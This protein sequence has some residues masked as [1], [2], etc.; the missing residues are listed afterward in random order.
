MSA[1]VVYKI[2]IGYQDF[3]TRILRVVKQNF[4]LYIPDAL[5][6]VLLIIPPYNLEK[7]LSIIG[8]LLILGI[9]DIIIM[10]RNIKY[11]N[12]FEVHNGLVYFSI[13]KYSDVYINDH[14]HITNIDMEWIESK[15][16]C[17]LVI[18]RKNS[19]IHTQYAIGYWTKNRLKELYKEFKEIKN[20][21][22]IEDIFRGPILN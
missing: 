19:I 15:N 12:N 10:K 4:L 8:G 6:I 14:D 2:E 5:L 1:D 11:L 7:T 9:R 3:T 18:K 22:N 16:N 20:D 17:R 13:L 21:N